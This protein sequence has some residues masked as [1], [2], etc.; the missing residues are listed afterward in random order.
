MENVVSYYKT[1][2]EEVI[3]CGDYNAHLNK[4]EESETKRFLNIME[5]ADLKQH[6]TG[7]THVKGN[8]IDLAMT[9]SNSTLI[10]N[11]MVG[12]FLSDHAVIHVELDLR[13]PARSKKEIKFRKNDI[14]MDVLEAKIDSNLKDIDSID[15]LPTLVDKFNKAL[16]DAYDK[17]APLQSKVIIIRPPTPWS[18]DDI[19]KDKAN[20]RKLERKWRRTS[21]QVDWEI[22]RDFWNYFNNKLNQLRNKQ[23]SEMIEKNKNDPS[24]LFKVINNLL[25]N[26]QCSPLPTGLSNKQLAEKFSDFFTE[27][28]DRIRAGLDQN[29]YV[30]EVSDPYSDDIHHQTDGMADLNE[31][32]LLTE[33]EVE[34]VIKDFPNKQCRLDPLPMEMLKKCLHVVIAPI[35]KIVNLSLRLGDLPDKLKMAIIRPLIKKLGLEL[36]LRNYRPVSNLSF[37]SKLI[38]KIVAKQFVDHLIKNNLIDPFQSA[39]KKYHSTE[40]TL[41]KV[42]NDILR[43]IDKKNVSLLILL[44]LSAAFDTIDHGILLKRLERYYKIKG[45]VHN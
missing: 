27:K 2:N 11:C 45:T 28:I 26:K 39:Y 8:T 1:V 10:R 31:F 5:S 17:L 43:D 23:Y 7:K 13:K 6:V 4:P 24:T 44:D 12:G 37:L 33:K 41:L 3:F 22:Y 21:L 9:E 18:Y 34:E 20:R 25:H 16:S 38:E 30:G 40:T 32:S 36:E 15:D 14:D 29:D 35:T 42:Q 19:K